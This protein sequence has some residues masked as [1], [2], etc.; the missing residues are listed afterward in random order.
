MR[1]SLKVGK[2]ISK[3]GFRYRGTNPSRLES[4]TDAVFGFSITLLVIS[5]EVP[6]SYLELQSSMYGF[7]GFVICTLLLLSLWNDHY[8]FFLRYGLEDGVTKALNFLFLFLLLYYVYPLKYLFNL[9]GTFFWLKIKMAFGDKSE[10]IQMKIAE[11]QEMNLQ[12]EQWQDLMIRFGVGL[13][14]IYSIFLLWHVHAYRKREELEL[15]ELEV[16]ETKVEIGGKLIMIVVPIVSMLFVLTGGGLMA[17]FAG[18]SYMLY[19]ILL[20]IYYSRASRKRK[21]LFPN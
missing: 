21:Q 20:P 6:K 11:F 2:E 19:G 17:P 4:I 15:N 5:L 14:A 12:P 13:M 7:L 18:M 16:Y 9:L 10:A 3:E 1:Q 8:R